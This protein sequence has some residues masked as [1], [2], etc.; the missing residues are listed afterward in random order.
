[1]QAGLGGRRG[2]DELRGPGRARPP[3]AVGRPVLRP[4]CARAARSGEHARPSSCRL[5]AVRPA[6]LRRARG[7]VRAIFESLA[8]KYRLVLE[9]IELVT[10]TPIE[11]IHVIGGGAQN[12]FLC[13]LTANVARRPRSRRARRGGCARERPRPA[14][15]GGRARLAGGHARARPQLDRGSR[16]RA[17]SR[18]R[19]SGRRSTIGSSRPSA[20]F[21]CDRRLPCERRLRLAGGGARGTR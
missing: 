3:S 6:G 9:Q 20:R 4:R 19:R 2:D 16:L 11:V 14:P 1:M 13:R 15:G 21:V 10:G 17:G 7:A 12:D 5:R 8:C 18:S